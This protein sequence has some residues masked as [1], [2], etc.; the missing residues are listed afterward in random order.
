MLYGDKSVRCDFI[1]TPD[2]SIFPFIILQRSREKK[3]FHTDT[4]QLWKEGREGQR[5][6]N[7]RINYTIFIPTKWLRLLTI[8]HSLV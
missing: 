7:V 5:H 3:K 2:G 4:Q 1:C 8:G 6:G